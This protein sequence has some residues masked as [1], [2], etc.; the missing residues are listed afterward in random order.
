MRTV[1]RANTLKCAVNVKLPETDRWLSE[2]QCSWWEFPSDPRRWLSRAQAAPRTWSLSFNFKV[3]VWIKYFTMWMWS[4]K[5]TSCN[6]TEHR[7]QHRTQCALR[8]RDTLPVLQLCSSETTA[9]KRFRAFFLLLQT[10]FRCIPPPTVQECV[11]QFHIPGS[12]CNQ[13]TVTTR[14]VPIPVVVH[15]VSQTQWSEMQILPSVL[16]RGPLQKCPPH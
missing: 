15:S 1:Q 2:A 4:R 6:T 8:C 7:A 10:A 12:Q 3:Y 16:C 13:F 9:R 5:I 11:S 14:S